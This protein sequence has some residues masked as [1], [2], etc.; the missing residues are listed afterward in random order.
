MKIVKVLYKGSNFW[1]ILDGRS[2]QLLKGP[3]YKKIKP[4]TRKVSFSKCKLLAPADPSKIILAGLNY[5]DHAKELKMR[6]PKEPVIFLKSPTALIGHKGKIIYPKEV[7]RLDYE[8]ELAM[9]I[10]KKCKNVTQKDADKYILGYTCLND[11]T[12]R[13]L[14]SKDIQWARAKSFDTFCPLG[15]WIETN[16]S[17]ENLNIR[18]YLNG[19]LKQDSTTKHFIFSVKYLVSFIS[20]IMTLLPGDIISTGTPQ[21]VGPMG[22]DD[23]TVVEIDGVGRL[24]NKVA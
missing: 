5:T 22:R 24:E 15:P 17:P 16:V 11:V 23:K 2:V 20:K 4:S 18:L 12:A 21:G 14:Q 6:L 3:P 7:K 10:S 8:A 13:D 1:G 19:K 9:V